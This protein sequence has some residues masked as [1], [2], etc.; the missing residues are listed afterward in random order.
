MARIEQK[1][2]AIVRMAN[3]YTRRSYGR[4]TEI[5]GVMAHSLPDLLGYGT[6]EFLHERRRSVDEKLLALAGTK[7][8]C[9]IGCQFCKTGEDGRLLIGL[10]ASVS[11]VCPPL[12]SCPS[13]RAHLRPENTVAVNIPTR[14]I[15]RTEA[16][17]DAA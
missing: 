4:D 8:A 17:P 5:A 10:P 6:F 15:A 11:Q 7:A 12:R 3:W 13:C 9:L 2:N 16:T 14:R 1:Q